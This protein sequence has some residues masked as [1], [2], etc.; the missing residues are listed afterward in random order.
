MGVLGPDISALLVLL[1]H[2][3]NAVWLAKCQVRPT[4]CGMWR[5]NGC[6]IIFSVH[7][8]KAMHEG[9]FLHYIKPSSFV[10]SPEF[11]AASKKDKEEDIDHQVKIPA[12]SKQSKHGLPISCNLLYD[13][14][15]E[16]SE[17]Q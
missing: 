1:P 12:I 14:I 6:I 2:Q 17:K 10:D 15:N 16:I 3:T 4:S 8:L 5:C 13:T 7:R 11:E 9:T